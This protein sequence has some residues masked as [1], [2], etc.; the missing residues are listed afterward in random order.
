MSVDNLPRKP[1]SG[2]TQQSSLV[3]GAEPPYDGGMESRIQR[4]EADVAAIKEDVAV[5]RAN[6][7]HFVT[8][9]D[10][11]NQLT[12]LVKWIVGT[13]IGLGVAAVTVMTFVLNNATP[14]ANTTPVVIYVPYPPQQYAPA[15]PAL[16]SQK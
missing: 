16:P 5:L 4:L 12:S 6:S 13:A 15:L 10:L 8:K 1:R 2:S 11:Q 14:K 7:E 3:R 9:A